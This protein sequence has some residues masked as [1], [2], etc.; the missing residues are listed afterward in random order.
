M[1]HI[2]GL[3]SVWFGGHKSVSSQG[4]HDLIDYHTFIVEATND[5]QTVG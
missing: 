3:R 5:A 1:P 4:D 2:V